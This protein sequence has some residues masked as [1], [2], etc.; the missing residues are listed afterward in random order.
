MDQ[1]LKD[2]TVRDVIALPLEIG[3]GVT[4]LGL[5]VAGQA[6][7]AGMRALGRLISPANRGPTSGAV[8][9][10]EVSGAARVDV[11]IAA[12]ETPPVPSPAP[13]PE[14]EPAHV[15]E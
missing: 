5:R 6:A 11:D 3:R 12:P 15:S 8:Q 1:R 7:G 14:A 2:H 4:G 13:E 10:E 9:D